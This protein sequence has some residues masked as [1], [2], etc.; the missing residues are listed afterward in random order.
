MLDDDVLRFSS[1][2]A[3]S[4]I[5]WRVLAYYAGC[6]A[7]G[8]VLLLLSSWQWFRKPILV[9][10][11][12][13]ARAQDAEF[14]VITAADGAYEVCPVEPLAAVQ[15]ELLAPGSAERRARLAV[16]PQRLP[17]ASRMI[18]YRHCRFVLSPDGLFTLLE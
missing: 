6:V 9:W 8:G 13:P 5:R 4:Y 1:F 14:A 18:V 17:L 3:R 2:D 12:S 16:P 10:M 15:L 7:T 11:S